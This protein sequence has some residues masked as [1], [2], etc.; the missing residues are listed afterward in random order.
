M[1]RIPTRR[2]IWGWMMF[3]WA[4]QPYNT[5]LLTFI[6]GPFFAEMVIDRM[7]AAGLSEEAARAEAQAYWGYGL[8]TAGLLIAVLA[9]VLGAIADST[10]RR[11]PWIWVFSGLYVVGAAGLWLAVATAVLL[12]L[13]GVVGHA[14]HSRR[15]KRGV[16]LLAIAG[17]LALGTGQTRILLGSGHSRILLGAWHSGGS[18]GSCEHS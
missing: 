13:L 2:R 10:G 11:M 14:G 6:F 8:T 7:T 16:L 1:D 15:R 9:P 4:S 17:L 18:H 3:D 12:V 5:L